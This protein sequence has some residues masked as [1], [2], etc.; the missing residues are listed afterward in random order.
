MQSRDTI[1]ALA[2]APGQAA[3]AVLR[4]SGAE[5]RALVEAALRF[6][7]RSEGLSHRRAQRAALVDPS[8]ASV[9]DEV[10]VTFFAAPHSYTGEDL[11]EIGLH[12]NPWIVAEA[13]RIL[14]RLGARPAAPGEFTRRALL[15]GKL[16]LARAE[17]IAELV[18]AQSS[19]AARLAVRQIGGALSN[20][21]QK[22]HGALT[23]ILSSLEGPLDFPEE[24]G[25]DDR[26]ASDQAAASLGEVIGE[27]R[28]LAA[29]HALA[30][31]V[32][33][34]VE[35]PIVGRPNVGKSSIFNA[36][37]DH[38][39]AIVSARAGT[40]R[41]TIE[42]PIQLAGRLARLVDTAGFQTTDDELEAEGV[43]RG[44]ERVARA[45]LVVLVLDASS[46]L[47]D[48]DA[49]LVHALA[50]R[51]ML[52]VLNKIDLARRIGAAEV[53]RLGIPFPPVEVSARTGL[54]LDRL[55]AALAREVSGAGAA[56]R[57]SSVDTPVT[58]ARQHGLLVRAVGELEHAAAN[59]G[60]GAA[61]LSIEDVRAAL[62]VLEELVGKVAS[63]EILDGV[64]ARFCIGK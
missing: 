10:L 13:L 19:E 31:R 8:D 57:G 63:E 41:D 36:L 7:S 12:G 28:E 48:G 21:Y 17:A 16:D 22:I 43:R 23:N 54:G 55:R 26:A 15:N 18:L 24:A 30:E 9:I 4:V 32:T 47:S 52:P 5:T 50:G 34:G 35:I 59:V 51:A 45:D 60:A 33:G 11:A 44:Q 42:A 58:S 39:R 3:V 64:F 2:T 46:P 37:L 20:R 6:P 40:T 61:E 49:N 53:L 62:R 1:A 27:L 38:E 29:S 56:S 14:T 25:D